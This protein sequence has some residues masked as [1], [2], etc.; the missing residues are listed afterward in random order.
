MRSASGAIAA[1]L[2]AGAFQRQL[3][4]P[5]LAAA[6]CERREVRSMTGADV[7]VVPAEADRGSRFVTLTA[8]GYEIHDRS[9]RKRRLG[10]R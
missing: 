7:M 1:A 2:P 8:I 6:P 9:S 10:A 3:L 4:R 5:L